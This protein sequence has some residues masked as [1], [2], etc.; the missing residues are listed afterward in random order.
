MPPA[1]PARMSLTARR[2]G[3][4]EEAAVGMDGA[5]TA[6]GGATALRGMTALVRGGGCVQV[7]ELRVEVG[8]REFECCQRYFARQQTRSPRLKATGDTV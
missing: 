8:Q 4:V 3:E 2:S 5:V 6:G 7:R 1:V